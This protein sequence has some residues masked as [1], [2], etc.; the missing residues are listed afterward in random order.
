MVITGLHSPFTVLVE[1][2]YEIQLKKVFNILKSAKKQ[3]N[4]QLRGKSQCDM[5]RF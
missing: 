1:S 3:E 4:M 2:E 5:V